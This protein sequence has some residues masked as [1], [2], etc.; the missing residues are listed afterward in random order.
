MDTESAYLSDLSDLSN[1]NDLTDLT[2][3]TTIDFLLENLYID[4][5]LDYIFYIMYPLSEMSGTMTNLT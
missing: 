1:S 4:N 2:D 3:L 5:I